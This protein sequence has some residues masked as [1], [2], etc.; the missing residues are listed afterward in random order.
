MRLVVT[1]VLILLVGGATFATG[2]SIQNEVVTAIGIGVTACSLVIL[3][4]LWIRLVYKK[5]RP[6]GQGDDSRVLPVSEGSMKRNKSDTNLE[7]ISVQVVK[8]NDAYG[9]F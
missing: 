6:Q 9:D 3:S 1:S 2:I 7:L 8:E 5:A 4:L